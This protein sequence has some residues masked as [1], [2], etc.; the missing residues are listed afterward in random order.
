MTN[1]KLLLNRAELL[2][3]RRHRV[4]YGASYAVSE[5]EV[6]EALSLVR[7]LLPVLK[8]AVSEVPESGEVESDRS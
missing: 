7:D 4:T 3:R 1:H 6:E 8:H 5:H 2:R